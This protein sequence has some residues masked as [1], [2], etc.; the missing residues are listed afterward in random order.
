MPESRFDAWM[1]ERHDALWPE[2]LDPVVVEQT[3]EF[4]ADWAEAGRALEF[5]VGTGRITLPL[6]RRGVRVHGID[7]HLQWRHN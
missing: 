4:L 1:A 2:L 3:V 6:S 5:G 7:C